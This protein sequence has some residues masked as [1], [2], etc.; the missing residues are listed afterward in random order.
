MAARG[1]PA[2]EQRGLFQGNR[3]AR[4]NR[5]EHSNIRFTLEDMERLVA[6]GD[7]LS[8]LLVTNSV[9]INTNPGPDA[10]VAGTPPEEAREIF[11]VNVLGTVWA[12]QASWP[13]F[14]HQGSG[15]VVIV[16]SAACN[17]G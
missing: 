6:D 16:S 13:V 12:I 10:T 11:D 9:I 2:V 15:H 1:T 4:L 5:L 8:A 14:R 17:C 3:L 7:P